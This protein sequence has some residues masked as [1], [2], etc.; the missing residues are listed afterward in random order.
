MATLRQEPE[1][2]DVDGWRK[3]VEELRDEQISNPSPT[4][5]FYAETHL[6]A[7]EKIAP[8]LAPEAA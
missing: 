1:L 3:L 4:A 8:N 6:A 2:F 5:L 7:I